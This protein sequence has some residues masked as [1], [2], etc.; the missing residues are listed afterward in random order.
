MSV[1]LEGPGGLESAVGSVRGTGRAQT[2]LSRSLRPPVR[3]WA[4]RGWRQALVAAFVVMFVTA[5]VI[6]A[7][8]GSAASGV[9]LLL[10]VWF[11]VVYRRRYRVAHPQWQAQRAVWAR[12]LCCRRCDGVFLPADD[13]ATHARGRLVERHAMPAFLTECVGS[14]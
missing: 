1:R 13:T 9:A 6:N 7:I 2:S 4:A 12:L 5:V 10:A 8:L 11:L 14:R 3:P